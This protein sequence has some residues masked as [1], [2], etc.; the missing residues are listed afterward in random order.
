L[1]DEKGIGVYM[2]L[3]SRDDIKKLALISRLELPEDKIDAVAKH[4]DAVLMYAARVK[5]ITGNV[6]VGRNKLTNVV[7][8]DVV[9]RTNPETILAQAPQRE[10][11]F[12]VVPTII[13][14]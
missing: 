13:E 9:V 2:A 12:F 3:L 6:T 8:E 11:N 7:R 14:K 10:E 5:D 4:V 1:E